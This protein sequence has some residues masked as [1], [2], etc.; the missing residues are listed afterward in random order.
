MA[1]GLQGA[2]TVLPRGGLC[3]VHRRLRGRTMMMPVRRVQQTVT[4]RL[5]GGPTVRDGAVAGS[6]RIL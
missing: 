3:G 1:P 4:G 5:Q 6:T 2:A